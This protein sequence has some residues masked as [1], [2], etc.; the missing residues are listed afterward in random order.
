MRDNTWQIG[1]FPCETTREPLSHV[2]IIG[3]KEPHGSFLR[4]G[5]HT[6]AVVAEDM[7]L[8]PRRRRREDFTHAPR[9]IGAMARMGRIA[10]DPTVKVLANDGPRSNACTYGRFRLSMANRKGLY[11][12]EC[13]L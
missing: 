11:C 2:G 3:P 9:S 7:I 4:L 5:L 10:K 1:A 13:L 12:V 8:S 6:E